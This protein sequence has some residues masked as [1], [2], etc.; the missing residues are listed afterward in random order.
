MESLQQIQ[1]NLAKI[2][3]LDEAIAQFQNEQEQKKSNQANQIIDYENL[4]LQLLLEEYEQQQEISKRLISEN[5][6][7]KQQL[8]E[9]KLNYTKIQT[10]FADFQQKLQESMESTKQEIENQQKEEEIASIKE[11]KRLQ[12]SLNALQ[13]KHEKLLEE[14]RIL[15][16]KVSKV[17]GTLTPRRRLKK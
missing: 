1:A 16:N 3:E 8:Q 11:E 6:Q 13:E 10:E 15:Q 2:K 5:Q 7:L 12:Q 4:E 17:K 9:T 14:K